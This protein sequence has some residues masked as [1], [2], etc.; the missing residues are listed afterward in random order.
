VTID[1]HEVTAA[2]RAEAQTVLVPRGASTPGR[3][4]RNFRR[5]LLGWVLFIAL[6]V[7]LMMLLGGEKPRGVRG[8]IPRAG[9]LA[10]C[11]AYVVGLIAIFASVRMLR[12]L[13]EQEEALLPSA[14]YRFAEVGLVMTRGARSR[15][16]YWK[17]FHSF[18][19][20]ENLFVVR[21]RPD[22]GAIFPKRQFPDAAA[23]DATRH[24]LA[25]KLAIPAQG[26]WRR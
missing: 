15:T 1:R 24:L 21:E 13:K 14:A 3:P 19:E 5:G 18:A 25:E 23:V 2:D 4:A 6:A 9:I 8:V 7:M 20:T 10:G 22:L 12:R 26:E 17:M 11:A 16:T